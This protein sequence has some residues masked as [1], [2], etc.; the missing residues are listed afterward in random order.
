MLQRIE[1]LRPHKVSDTLSVNNIRLLISTLARPLAEL[2]R[3]QLVNVRLIE[4]KLQEVRATGLS[5]EN[6]I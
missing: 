6:T 2:A 4:E 1:E 3:N 5:I